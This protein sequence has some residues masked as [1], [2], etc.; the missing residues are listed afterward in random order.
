M[1]KE[2]DQRHQ[3]DKTGKPDDKYFV[4]DNNK[5][6]FVLPPMGPLFPSS[7]QR[8]ASDSARDHYQRPPSPFSNIFCCSERDSDV[9]L[10]A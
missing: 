9:R 7:R 4:I 8:I 6:N 10:D 5:T 1:F 3:N 2:A